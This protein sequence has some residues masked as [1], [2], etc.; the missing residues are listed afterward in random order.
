[1]INMLDNETTI[2][3]FKCKAKSW[4]QTDNDTRETWTLIK[5]YNVKVKFIW[6]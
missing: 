4:V 2:K 6:L 5:N 1:M 3:P